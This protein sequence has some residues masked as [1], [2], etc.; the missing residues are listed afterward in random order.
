MSPPDDRAWS[1]EGNNPPKNFSGNCMP[2]G[3]LR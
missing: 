1:N 3:K 2:F